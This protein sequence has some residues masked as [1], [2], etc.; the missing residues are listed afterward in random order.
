MPFPAIP[1][2]PLYSKTNFRCSAL[3]PIVESEVDLE[4]PCNES[5][6]S[7]SA[8]LK[9]STIT[10]T[11]PRS[12]SDTPLTTTHGPWSFSSGAPFF[13]VHSDGA[14]NFHPSGVMPSGS[15]NSHSTG[16]QK[17]TTTTHSPTTTSKIS[18]DVEVRPS[19]HLSPNLPTSLP[20]FEEGEAPRSETPPKTVTTHEVVTKM[21]TKTV[22]V[23]MNTVTAELQA[24]VNAITRISPGIFTEKAE[25]PASEPCDTLTTTSKSAEAK[26]TE[27]TEKPTTGAPSSTNTHSTSSVATTSTHTISIA[28][29]SGEVQ[30]GI[31]QATGMPRPESS[32]SLPP[33]PKSSLVNSSEVLPVQST[34]AAATI[35]SIASHVENIIPTP[36]PNMATSTATTLMTSTK[37]SAQSVE[38]ASAVV[39]SQ[40]VA[41]GSGTSLV[42]ASLSAQLGNKQ[43]DGS[44]GATIT[45]SATYEPSAGSTCTLTF[46]HKPSVFGCK[47]TSWAS[48]V[49]VSLPCSGCH[50]LDTTTAAYDE[51]WKKNH[52][53]KIYV[54]FE[55]MNHSSRYS[56]TNILLCAV[57]RRSSERD[58]HAASLDPHYVRDPVSRPS[59]HDNGNGHHYSF[60]DSVERRNTEHWP[61]CD[62]C[63]WQHE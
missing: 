27:K 3:V 9:P 36:V 15:E 48:T 28:P 40:M 59:D 16:S 20:G 2:G 31:P 41:P 17:M 11:N 63:S 62:D 51:A 14:P 53:G 45:P 57:L 60:R 29:S 32:N 56:I 58:H 54:S 4:V 25:K 24:I 52:G 6:V 12:L 13:P 37:Q 43:V 55:S 26:S 8:F 22:T 34:A 18:L 39:S 1:N 19:T 33:P 44:P 61:C 49:T 38:P 7:H 30:D 5:S 46:N 23:P 50:T 35:A 47:T 42:S 21:E 10:P